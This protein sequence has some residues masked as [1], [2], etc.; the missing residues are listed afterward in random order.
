MIRSFACALALCALAV[1]ASADEPEP[2][3]QLR[4]HKFSAPERK[5]ITVA[6]FMKQDR[7]GEPIYYQ[8]GRSYGENDN[9]EGRS[10]GWTDTRCPGSRA[11]LERLARLQMPQP[12]VPGLLSNNSAEA[13]MDGWSYSLEGPADAPYRQN[14]MKLTSD[15]GS[16]LAHWVDE[17]LAILEPCWVY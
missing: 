9:R 16:P 13:T 11:A 17:T 12:L 14:Y 5:I 7:T 8:F 1:S 15:A 2:P 3:S 6:V 10:A 4:F